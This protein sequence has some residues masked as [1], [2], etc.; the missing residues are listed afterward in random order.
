MCGYA[1]QNYGRRAVLEQVGVEPTGEAFNKRGMKRCRAADENKREEQT[2]DPQVSSPSG[3]SKKTHQDWWGFRGR[4]RDG[5]V[6][7][8]GHYTT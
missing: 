5:G 4:N 3:Q 2:T 7:I 8:G 6:V 1:L